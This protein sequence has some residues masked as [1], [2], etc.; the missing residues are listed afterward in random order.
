MA[1]LDKFKVSDYAH[2]LWY[3]D[4]KIAKDM[5]KEQLEPRFE[6]GLTYLNIGQ[7][8]IPFFNFK[9]KD[10]QKQKQ[11]HWPSLISFLADNKIEILNLSKCQM[12]K[13]DMEL[14][15]TCIYQNPIAPTRLRVLNLR[16]NQIMKDGA[17][18]LAAALEG[19]NSI[20]VLDLS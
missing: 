14:I 19:N 3:G 8:A 16:K 17:K 10:Y 12:N 9:L 2:E 1:F 15:S 4:A 5:T 20:E 6:F 11:P 18:T 7:S 13:N